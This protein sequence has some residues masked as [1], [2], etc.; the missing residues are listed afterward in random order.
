MV[1]VLFFLAGTAVTTWAGNVSADAIIGEYYAPDKDASIV[2][3][4]DDGRYFARFNWSKSN[5]PRILNKMFMF[6]L[7]YRN[8][9]WINGYLINPE[10]GKKYFCMAWLDEKNNLV[11]KGSLDRMGILGGKRVFPFKS[12]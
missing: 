4:E 3:Y 10:N 2:I 11:I 12:K 7:E 5:D 1:I 8:G 9:K 6:D